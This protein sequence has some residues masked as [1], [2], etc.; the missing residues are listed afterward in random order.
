V[1]VTVLND[2]RMLTSGV[3][4]TG[5]WFKNGETSVTKTSSGVTGSDGVGVATIT[6]GAIKGASSLQFCV[7]GL[8]GTGFSDAR[9][10][11]IDPVCSS[12]EA[13]GGGGGGLGDVPTTDLTATL[14]TNRGGKTKVRLSWTPWSVT[15]VDVWLINGGVI[16][17]IENSGS[18]TDNKGA[19]ADIYKVCEADTSACTNEAPAN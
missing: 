2:G 18:Y 10:Y 11:A 14:S 3:T 13:G 5:D 6:S 17:T 15:P 1:Q 19:D 12:P 16:A 7:T 4:V 9:D 8:S